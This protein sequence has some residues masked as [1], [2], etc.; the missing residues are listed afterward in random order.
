VTEVDGDAVS[1]VSLDGTLEE[2]TFS[3]LLATAS[4]AQMESPARCDFV[5]IDL[6]ETQ[7]LAWQHLSEPAFNRALS[8]IA[9]IGYGDHTPDVVDDGVPSFVHEVFELT[10]ADELAAH[11]SAVFTDLQDMA[12]KKL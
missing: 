3:G 10:A 5:R 1:L 2:G 11:S 4:D 8:D 7:S 9:M 12:K 6:S